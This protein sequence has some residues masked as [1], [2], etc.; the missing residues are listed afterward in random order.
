MKNT[1]FDTEKTWGPNPSRLIAE[2][3]AG[4]KVHRATLNRWTHRYPEFRD[5]VKIGR[6]LCEAWYI[7]LGRSAML[8]ASVRVDG[9]AC[10]PQ[11]GWFVWMTKNMF[12]W[13]DRAQLEHSGPDGNPIQTQNS[14]SDLTDAELNAKL[15]L[16]LAKMNK[17]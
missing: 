12:K 6:E 15:D 4:W 9:A 3:A 7:K 1:R 10:K 17:K 2:I 11:L 5:S 16:L 13:N 14:H 8:G